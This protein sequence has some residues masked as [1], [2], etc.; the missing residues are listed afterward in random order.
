MFALLRALS[1]SRYAP[2]VYVIADTDTTSASKV[3]AHESKLRERF[4]ADGTVDDIDSVRS[5]EHVVLKTPRSREVGQRF[6]TSVCTTLRAVKRAAWITVTQKPDL[7]LTNGP[8]TCVPLCFAAF[9]LRVCA[10]VT[11]SKRGP[12]VAYVESVCRVA[13]LSLTGEILYRFRLA[14]IVFVQ[15]EQMLEKYPR[16]VYAG[17]VV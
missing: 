6:L 14:D 11:K 5:T 8:G 9:C 12:A 15:W 7:V 4:A 2:R 3:R 13:S 1:P 10:P 16:A 17:R